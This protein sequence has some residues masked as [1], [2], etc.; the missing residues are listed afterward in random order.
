[1]VSSPVL[2]RVSLKYGGVFERAPIDRG[3]KMIAVKFAKGKRQGRRRT[4]QTK[5]L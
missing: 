2:V 4:H 3:K 5:G 1:M